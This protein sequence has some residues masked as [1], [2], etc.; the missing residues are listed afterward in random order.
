MGE[1]LFS[2]AFARIL[3]AV[4]PEIR[5]ARLAR[6]FFAQLE[7]FGSEAQFFFFLNASACAGKRWFSALAP[8][9]FYGDEN[10]SQASKHC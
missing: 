2:V 10:Q 5:I 7:L 4:V 1:W 8:V 9:K 6:V 3:F